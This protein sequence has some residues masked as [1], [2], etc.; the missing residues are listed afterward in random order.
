MAVFQVIPG[1]G[2]CPLIH[3]FLDCASSRDK[4]GLFPVL[5]NTLFYWPG[6]FAEASQQL[7]TRWVSLLLPPLRLLKGKG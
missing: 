7:K 1:L 5:C 6:D 3:S 2:G 4:P